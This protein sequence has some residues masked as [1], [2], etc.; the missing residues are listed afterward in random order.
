MSTNRR[1]ARERA[2]GLLY[3]AE[4]RGVAP[5]EVLADLPVV[6][7]PYAVEL[8]EGVAARLTD[9]DSL[10]STYAK[11]WKL[12]RM[13]AIDRAILRLATFEL[14]DR[15]DVPTGVAISEAVAMASSYSTEESGR[16]VN[17]LVS[18][19]SR[20]VRPVGE[21]GAPRRG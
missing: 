1:D 6:P 13:P 20:E 18:R 4:A 17:G 16:F 2:L 19:I 12:E 9:I 8:V 21:D 11:G 5:D 14:L 7:D 10:I 15:P 3:E